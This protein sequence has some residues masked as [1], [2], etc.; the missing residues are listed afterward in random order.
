[1][2]RYI[3]DKW[4]RGRFGKEYDECPDL[5]KKRRW[6]KHLGLGREKIFGWSFPRQT[7]PGISSRTV[8]CL[9]FYEDYIK[10]DNYID[11]HR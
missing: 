11:T 1:L 3:Q 6:D 10:G 5:E 2:F 4:N 8:S 9:Q 7:S